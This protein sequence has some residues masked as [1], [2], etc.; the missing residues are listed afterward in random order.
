MLIA[1]SIIS[2]AALQLP[3][4]GLNYPVNQNPHLQSVWSQSADSR[5]LLP[6]LQA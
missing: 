4:W 3:F 5:G 1:L 2:Q 6:L